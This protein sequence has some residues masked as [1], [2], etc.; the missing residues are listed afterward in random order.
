METTWFSKNFAVS[1]YIHYE[2]IV[3]QGQ[4]IKL[5]EKS[6]ILSLVQ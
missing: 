4:L 2:L 6:R 1:I 3:L 5:K